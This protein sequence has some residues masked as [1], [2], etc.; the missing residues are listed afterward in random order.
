[1]LVDRPAAIKGAM[2]GEVL[3]IVCDPVRRAAVLLR[4][5]SGVREMQTFGDRLNVLVPD[6]AAV[7]ESL[8]RLLEDGGV[9]V[10][11]LRRIAPTL[12]NVFISLLTHSDHPSV[13]S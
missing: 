4:E 10:V 7:G 6:A 5:A 13:Q 12:E 9:R 3:E 1:M 8:R 11:A 2:S